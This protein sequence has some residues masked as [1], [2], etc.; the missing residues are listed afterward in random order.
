M[1]SIL[2]SL[3]KEKPIGKIAFFCLTAFLLAPPDLSAIHAILKDGEPI[4]RAVGSIALE[5][6]IETFLKTTEGIETPKAIGQFED[7][8][9]FQLD[10][11]P[12]ATGIKNLVCDFFQGVLFRIEVNY[13]P[14]GEDAASLNPLIEAWTRRFGS[15]RINTFSGTRLFF[16]DDGA[17]RMI[18]EIDESAALQTYSVTYIDDDLFHRISRER[19]QRETSGQSSYGK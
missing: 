14:L 16:W 18:L 10:G 1:I 8:H 17:T 3:L 11:L 4:P 5:M 13:P 19:V 2:I 12:A 15:P 9:R 7:E 6:P